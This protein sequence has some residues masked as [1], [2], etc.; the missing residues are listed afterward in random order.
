MENLTSYLTENHP[1]LSNKV[2]TLVLL[3]RLVAHLAAVFITAW[4]LFS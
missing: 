1:V 3:G 4:T 2:D